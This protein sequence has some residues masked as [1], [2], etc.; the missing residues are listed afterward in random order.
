MS[1][2]DKD[3]TRDKLVTKLKSVLRLTDL[4]ADEVEDAL[5]EYVDALIEDQL[6][7]E[8]DRGDYTR[9]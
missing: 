5:R 9:Y 3:R 1:W 2:K 4:E 6:D 8:H 7:R